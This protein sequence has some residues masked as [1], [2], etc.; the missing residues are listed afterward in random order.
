MN[1][2]HHGDSG[3]VNCSMS[4]GHDNSSSLTTAVIFVLP[5]PAA[6]SQPALVLAAPTM[7]V[8]AAFVPSY[9]PL[10]PPPRTSHF[11]L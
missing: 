10:S 11:S 8:P 1:C 9:D 3:I 7:F 2:A 4:C 5:G 6:I